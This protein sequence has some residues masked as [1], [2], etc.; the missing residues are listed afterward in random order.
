MPSRQ[1]VHKR[2]DL[3]TL[4]APGRDKVHHRALLFDHIVVILG[5]TQHDHALPGGQGV[6]GVRVLRGTCLKVG[7]A[8]FRVRD[9]GLLPGFPVGWA[10]LAVF[11][12][13][14]EGLQQAEGLV[15]RA[16]HGQVVH[17][18]LLQHAL[19]VDQ[20]QP[21]ERNADVF[22]QHAVIGR[23]GL[24]H[25]R[26]DG[27]LHVPQ[28]AALHARGGAERRRCCGLCKPSARQRVR[29]RCRKT[30]M[31][32]SF[33]GGADPGQVR[34]LRVRAQ[35]QDLGV[36][37]LEARSGVREGDDLRGADKSEVLGVK[38]QH[39]PFPPVISKINLCDLAIDDR[40]SFESWSRL[41][42][43][44]FRWRIRDSC[45]VSF[46]RNGWLETSDQWKA[47]QGPNGTCHTR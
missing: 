11:G 41:P 34:F 39:C 43:L 6:L 13:E 27:D 9:H 23:D 42:N 36:Q 16:A 8:P 40:S 3:P 38:E 20:E 19:R 37:G 33:S 45:E 17:R 12:H 18:D 15:H 31:V 14:L 32:Y 25:V 2:H 44:G 28:P 47:C 29:S 35:G 26:H 21:A 7:Q 1:L 10:H 30:K 46:G 5:G 4:A 22:Q 24:G